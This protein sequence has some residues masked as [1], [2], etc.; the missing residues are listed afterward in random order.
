MKGAK[1]S[2]PDAFIAWSYPPDT[3]GLTEQAIIENLQVKVFYTAVASSFPAYGGAFGSKINNTLGAGGSN[4]SDP[5]IAA[6]R[7]A[8]KAATGLD[9]DYWA[10]ANTYVSLQILEQAIEGVGKTDSA[11]VT[12]YIKT[13]TFDTIMGDISFDQQNSAKYWT[14]GQWQDG[15]FHGVKGSN[16]D[17]AVAVRVKDGWN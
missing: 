2:G 13:H 3:F 14:V 8:H 6:W 10:S 16:V 15:V 5:K 12:E 4:P 7:D 9:A 17:G 11:A 1:A